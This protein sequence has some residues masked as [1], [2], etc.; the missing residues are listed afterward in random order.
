MQVLFLSAV[1][2]I[3][4]E[5]GEATIEKALKRSRGID[6]KDEEL[7]I[8]W[9]LEN[10]LRPPPHLVDDAAPEINENGTIF[11]PEDQLDFEF[12]DFV[13]PMSSFFSAKDTLDFGCIVRDTLGKKHH[14]AQMAEEIYDY[15]YFI[16][17]PWHQKIKDW[18]RYKWNNFFSKK[19]SEGKDIIINLETKEITSE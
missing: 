17:R 16:N 11:L 18:L 7:G 10:N 6:G 2:K 12:L 19:E 15:I 3:P 1:T 4:N 5:A 8:D 9:Y 14:V 13:L